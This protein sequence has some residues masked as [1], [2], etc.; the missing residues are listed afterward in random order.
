MQKFIY[1]VT[2]N[3]QSLEFELKVFKDGYLL[4]YSH[5]INAM[6]NDTCIS[7]GKIANSVFAAPIQ[8]DVESI[9]KKF[10][11]FLST[12]VSYFYRKKDTPNMLWF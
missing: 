4:K 11:S 3:L 2:A 8:E 5:E 1:Q 7:L 6:I 10:E 9:V 12:Y